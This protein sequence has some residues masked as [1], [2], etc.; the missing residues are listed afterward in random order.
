MTSNNTLRQL[1][2]ARDELDEK[3][4]H[5]RERERLEAIATIHALM[6]TYAIKHSDLTGRNGRRGAY[7]VSALPALYRDPVSGQEWCGR[8][9]VPLWIRGK[10][11]RQFLIERQEQGKGGKRA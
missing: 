8:G 2:A 3:I 10:D 7:G 6:D 5:A 11:R 9:N 1:I 4:A